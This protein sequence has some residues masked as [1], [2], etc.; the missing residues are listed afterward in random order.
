MFRLFLTLYLRTRDFKK[1]LWQNCSPCLLNVSL[2]LAANSLVCCLIP[3]ESFWQKISPMFTL[4][5]SKLYGVCPMYSGKLSTTDTADREATGCRV[6]FKKRKMW[7]F[8]WEKPP[9]RSLFIWDGSGGKGARLL[10]AGQWWQLT[11]REI[12]ARVCKKTGIWESHSRTLCSHIIGQFASHYICHLNVGSCKSSDL[13]L[14]KRS[15]PS[16]R[17]RA[18]AHVQYAQATFVSHASGSFQWSTRSVY[19]L[20]PHWRWTH[21]PLNIKP[22]LNVWRKKAKSDL[23]KKKRDKNKRKKEVEGG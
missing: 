18:H 5:K 11:D 8:I 20:T 22:D 16:A 10:L 7:A 3:L 1:S 19:R 12:W 21:H 13:F 17:A 14:P 6:R 9:L 15:C 2:P 23:W 4:V